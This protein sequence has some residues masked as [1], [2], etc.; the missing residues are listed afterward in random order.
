[1][2]LPPHRGRG[3]GRS[4]HGRSQH[5][6]F[7]SVAQDQSAH[8]GQREHP[9]QGPSYDS[10]PAAHR[11]RHREDQ[12]GSLRGYDD[13]R[14]AVR[15]ST[16]DTPVGGLDDGAS[17]SYG[18]DGPVHGLTLQGSDRRGRRGGRYG[19][20]RGRGHNREVV[21]TVNGQLPDTV[22]GP[23]AEFHRQRGGR[24]GGRGGRASRS[25]QNGP[26]GDGATDAER[27]HPAGVPPAATAAI[28][29]AGAPPN[30]PGSSFTTQWHTEGAEAI[31]SGSDSE[32]E[33]LTCVICC[34]EV[35]AVAVGSCGHSH[36]CA[37]C[38]LRLR[39]CYRDLRCP[40]CKTVNNEVVVARPPLPPG[41]SFESLAGSQQQR[42]ALWQ[43]PKWAKGVLVYDPP[44]EGADRPSQPGQQQQQQHPGGGRRRPLHKSLQ[45][46]TSR[47]CSVCD[48]QGR[49][50]FGT[51]NLLLAHLR[52]AHDRLLCD[53]CLG[54]GL[55]FPLEYPT[56]DTAGLAKHM[57]SEHPRCEYCNL[58]FYGRDELYG[59][60]TQRHFTCHVCSRLG[61]HHLY[62]PDADTLLIHLRE[63]HYTCDHPDCFGCMIAFATRDELN[64]HIRDRHSSYMPRWDQSRAR[65]LLLDF[66]GTRGT[67]T[68]TATT[69]AA[70]AAA[71]SGRNSRS[72]DRSEQ[73][74]GRVAAA[75]AAAAAGREGA[76]PAGAISGSGT[77]RHTAQ[78][79][80]SRQGPSGRLGLEDPDAF[81]SLQS[82]HPLQEAQQQPH[83]PHPHHQGALGDMHDTEGGLAVIDDDLGLGPSRSL[84]AA[85]GTA[86]GRSR[87]SGAANGGAP[88]AA[89][90]GLPT[91]P[92][93]GT[94]A[95]G[96]RGLAGAWGGRQPGSGTF[97][98]DFP[99]L[100]IAAAST[101]AAASRSAWGPPS[102]RSAAAEPPGSSSAAS[103]PRSAAAT[104]ASLFSLRKVTVRCRC[105]NRVEHLALRPDEKAPE[106]VCDRDCTV[107][108]RRAQLAEAFGVAAADSHV[109]Y[110]DR[111]R[112]PNYTT[113]LILAAQAAGTEWVASV[114][115]DLAR[116]LADSSVRRTSLAAG[117]SQSQ[118][119]LVHEL[120]EHYGLVSHSIGQG[121]SRAVQ[122]L[123][124]AASGAP[125]R[126]LSVVAAATPAEELARLAS[127][128]GGAAGG[129]WVIKLVDVAPGTN[130]Q[131]YLRAW[132]GDY[133][134]TP[135]QGSSSSLQLTFHRESSFRDCRSR[136]GGGIRG[137]FRTEVEREHDG[138][139]PAAGPAAGSGPTAGGVALKPPAPLVAPPG[140]QVLRGN[141]AAAPVTRGKVGGTPAGA[142]AASSVRAA[143]AADAWASDDASPRPL[144]SQQRWHVAPDG[145]A[146]GAGGSKGDVAEG[147][148][149]GA[150]EPQLP[151]RGPPLDL[152][153]ATL[154]SALMM[155][156]EEQ[157]G[158][159]AGDAGGNGIGGLQGRKGSTL[160]SAQKTADIV[161]GGDGES[162]DELV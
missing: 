145:V 68:T 52:S 105:G 119:R 1:M 38:C 77:A 20:G 36:T 3:R 21:P 25:V 61:R 76:P 101:C 44:T 98:E 107:K 87:S 118:R 85:A 138:A 127:G 149:R 17:T 40:L 128:S 121:S 73:R 111:H 109:S 90:S 150:M 24:R 26:G 54:A 46:M 132:E 18:T 31:S 130:V 14:H 35:A 51:I 94:A 148:S 33:T 79:P 156:E 96:A 140:W 12:N 117:M 55:K 27:H 131:H 89:Q 72:D 10:A 135:V 48:S 147:P 160:A 120:A 8:A 16:E 116:F 125:T 100:S 141:K 154:W 161:G 142:D 106:L 50:P 67:T 69:T 103:P 47:S 88:S 158:G 86:A 75:A 7:N 97:R 32:G 13:G 28:A 37:R 91:G 29:A 66:M 152:A 15:P 151:G 134:A 139:R 93:S 126:L 113:E 81:P 114:E 39:L 83:H 58:V 104:A 57:A 49:R 112:T 99:E 162:W 133:T 124:G 137:V 157:N 34:E 70:P 42:E 41:T 144:Q 23:P 95:S 19:G 71:A 102:S 62:F 63:E 65:P 74:R 22:T 159:G 53:V 60:M 153:K 30:A 5:G 122:L 4:A 11:S 84:A 92:D 45:A 59:H 123:K 143:L 155:N 108:Q 2:S 43:Q 9:P 6:R 110:F 115:Q 56:Y 80:R 78:Q 146:G 82:Q 136:L 64:T 129:G